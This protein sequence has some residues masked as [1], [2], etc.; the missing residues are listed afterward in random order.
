MDEIASVGIKIDTSDIDGA[1]KNLDA[2]AGKGAAVDKSL[3]QIDAAAGRTGKSLDSL[4][5]SAGHAAGMDA[6]AKGAQQAA[7]GLQGMARG[8]DGVTS[9]TR[10]AAQEQEKLA[11]ILAGGAGQFTQAEQAHIRA[12]NTGRRDSRAD[13]RA[14]RSR[15]QR[16]RRG[17]RICRNRRAHWRAGGRV[18]QPA[19]NDGRG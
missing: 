18:F 2:L 14:E 12:L 5:K 1:I 11:K 13:Q 7:A 10:A 19:K 16:R 15:A 3:A 4:G 6:T 9:A 17:K 8:L